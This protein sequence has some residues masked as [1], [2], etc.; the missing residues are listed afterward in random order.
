MFYK[1][2]GPL[3]RGQTTLARIRASFNLS[4]VTTLTARLKSNMI[5]GTSLTIQ[6]PLIGLTDQYLS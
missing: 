6:I 5:L 1:S 3:L 2:I 4:D